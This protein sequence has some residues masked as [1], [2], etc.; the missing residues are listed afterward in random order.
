MLDGTQRVRDSG[1]SGMQAAR[2]MWRLVGVPPNSRLQVTAAPRLN[3]AVGQ[4]LSKDN[5]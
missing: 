2:G 4:V 1:G 5:Q 3:L